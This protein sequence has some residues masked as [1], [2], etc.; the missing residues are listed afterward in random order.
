MDMNY[1][2]Y[3]TVY[4][5]IIKAINNR[6]LTH[7]KRWHAFLFC[8]I[9]IYLYKVLK[10]KKERDEYYIQ[11]MTADFPIQVVLLELR[12]K[13]YI[14]G[15]EFRCTFG[16]KRLKIMLI[17]SDENKITIKKFNVNV[18]EYTSFDDALEEIED[19]MLYYGFDAD[20]EMNSDGYE[21]QD[22]YDDVY[23]NNR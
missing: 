7:G 23:Y 4:L 19:K 5:I 1:K 15:S 12:Q 13:G 6:G 9:L 20:D 21:L 14:R 8:K 10:G 11:P 3:T 16:G 22:L 2:I 18:N 17:L